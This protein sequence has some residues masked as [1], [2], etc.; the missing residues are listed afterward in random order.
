LCKHIELVVVDVWNFLL[1]DFAQLTAR[2]IFFLL[3]LLLHSLL[4][5]LFGWLNNLLLFFD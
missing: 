5:S 3:W 2:I 1:L 4:R